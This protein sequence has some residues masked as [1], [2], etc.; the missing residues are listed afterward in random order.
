M[1]Q[2]D[3]S[4]HSLDAL[5][6]PVSHYDSPQAVLRDAA[7]SATEKRSILSSWASDIYA[8]ESNPALRKIPGIARE[9]RLSDILSALRRLDDEDEA[10]PQASPHATDIRPRSLPQV[11]LNRARWSRE[12]NV[13]RYRK[14]LRTRLTEQERRFVEQRLAEEL[15]S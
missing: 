9:M 4:T 7:L 10:Q 3:R 1:S 11:A 6:H 15:Q 5:F 14:L 8:V 2:T 12:A 13:T